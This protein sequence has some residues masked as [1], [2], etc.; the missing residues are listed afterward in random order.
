LLWKEGLYALQQGE[1]VKATNL[2][3]FYKFVREPALAAAAVQLPR[4]K[5]HQ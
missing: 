4:T 5:H 1:V 3:E 2:Q